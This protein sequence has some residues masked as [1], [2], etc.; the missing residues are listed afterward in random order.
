[1]QTLRDRLAACTN[2]R[3]LAKDSGV[4]LRTLRRIKNGQTKDVKLTTVERINT[5][6]ARQG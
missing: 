5:A 3:Q 6:Q 2:L 4:D 1:M